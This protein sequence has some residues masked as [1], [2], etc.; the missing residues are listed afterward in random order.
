M[1]AEETLTLPGM[2]ASAH[3]RKDRALPSTSAAVKTDG[4]ASLS[5]RKGSRQ[6]LSEEY[7]QLTKVELPRLAASVKGFPIRFDHCFQRVALD[8]AFSGCWYDHLD[9]KKG[10]AIKQISTPALTRAVAV[11]H[12]MVSEGP[13]TVRQFDAMSLRWRGKEQKKRQKTA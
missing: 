6:A 8:H 7:M 10:P 3:K 9:R 12:R 1:A 13:G 5:P 4:S 2:F 11:C